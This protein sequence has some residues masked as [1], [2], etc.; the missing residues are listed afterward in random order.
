MYFVLCTVTPMPRNVFLLILSMSLG[1][2]GAPVIVLLGGII[3]VDLAPS[4]VWSTLPMAMMILGTAVFTIP[5]ALLMH[6]I[7]RRYGFMAG[8]VVAAG[9]SALG[10]Y[11]INAQS[12]LLFCSA[13]FLIGS[14]MAFVQQYRF[15]AA[16]SVPPEKVSR[17]VSLVLLGGIAAALIG[18]QIANQAKGLLTYGL[19]SGS[20]AVLSVLYLLNASVF[21]FFRE[22]EPVSHADE[23]EHRRLRTVVRQPLYLTAVLAGMVSYGV[24]AFIMTAT[25]IS[26]HVI[27]KFS[28]DQTTWVI[29]SHILAM[30]VPSLFTGSLI[31]RFGLSRIMSTGALLMT[32][33]VATALF[34]RDFVHYW[35]GLVLLGIGWNFLF[36]GGTTLLTRT[37]RPGERFRAQAVNDFS[38]FGFQAAASLS[39]GTVIFAFGWEVMNAASLPVLIFVLGAIIIQRHKIN[40]RG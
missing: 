23:G 4:P 40:G 10:V 17:A 18:P 25:P 34:N 13:T 5:A 28:L 20:F 37:Y 29:Q 11:A 1:L 35:L 36:V 30:F 6:V 7:G 26:M 3:G 31:A 9:A 14:N 24:M 15:G 16:E 12:F 33:C 27:D 8:S 22:P 19:Y 2:S 21:L 32:G 39:A 38:V